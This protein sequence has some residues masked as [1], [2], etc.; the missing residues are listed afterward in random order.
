MDW[1]FICAMI[2][3]LCILS[4]IV[5]STV[6]ALQPSSREQ[7]YVSYVVGFF[8]ICLLGY[9]ACFVA[10]DVS[11]LRF[12]LKVE[13][14]SGFV[15]Y[16]LICR[17]YQRIYNVKI[18]LV[19]NILLGSW[20]FFL[21]IICLTF[22]FSEDLALAHFFY[23]S[24]YMTAG[25]GGLWYL[26]YE[27][28]WAHTAY[29][30]TIIFYM[31]FT[32]A[33]FSYKLVRLK[34]AE[35]RDCF[36]FFFCIFCPQVAL[37]VLLGVGFSAGLFPFFPLVG[38]L[39]C[40]MMTVLIAQEKLTNLIACSHKVISGILEEPVFITDKEFYIYE[41]NTASLNMYPEL[42]FYSYRN[43]KN[44]RL[45]LDIQ[46]LVKDKPSVK[47]KGIT[48]RRGG[49]IYNVLVIPIERNERLYGY[50]FSLKDVTKHD[51]EADALNKK[52]QELEKALLRT[53][54]KIDL[55]REKSVSSYIQFCISK[56]PPTGLHMQRISNY[57]L[58]LSRQMQ[59]SGVYRE[60]LTDSYIRILVQVAPLHDIGKVLLSNSLFDDSKTLDERE[61]FL[62]RS[63]VTEG[64]KIIDRI[65][66]KSSE[67][68]YYKLSHEVTLY[69]HE[70]WNG[71]GY[72]SELKGL[73]IPLSARIVAIADVFDIL[74][75]RLK[76]QS[77][78]VTRVEDMI[79]D[80]SGV[81]FDPKIVI[82]FSE[83]LQELSDFFYSIN[84]SV[85]FIDD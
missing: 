45:P 52:N 68:L 20:T 25:K 55:L 51:S 6:L 63:H 48:Y 49:R 67:D 84:N 16:F 3:S 17:I 42:K 29:I 32:V 75:C 58:I 56:D 77:D 44:V 80:L 7:K 18:P 43:K 12:G 27:A 39:S 5:C 15:I 36:I 37:L 83:A 21:C 66:V 62:K 59:K 53:E 71:G 1:Y 34:N 9:T 74:M 10:S 28:G 64:A 14:L 82:A 40:I 23:K 60:T 26:S 65:M 47:G 76:G 30:A 79:K 61:L 46:D 11:L 8:L 81:R 22:N 50:V 35:R 73:E 70:W 19:F 78:A 2:L 72:E 13:F 24:Y 4:T 33:M 57:V 69:H 85:T 41:L 54:H 38:T 31:L